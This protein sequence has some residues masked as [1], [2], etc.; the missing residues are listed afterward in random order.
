MRS[1]VAVNCR[2]HDSVLRMPH[3]PQ[4]PDYFLGAEDRGQLLRRSRVGNLRDQLGPL[5]CDPIEESQRS[6]RLLECTPG[7]P[8]RFPQMDEV[9][10]DVFRG[11][12]IGRSTEISRKT[13]NLLNV[14]LLGPRRVVAY[15][16]ILEHPLAQGRHGNSL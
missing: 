5:Q 16:Q 6:D 15:T 2:Q 3:C 7:Y 9:G 8:V 13:R 1:P 14:D 12:L 10:P 11:Q 4:Q